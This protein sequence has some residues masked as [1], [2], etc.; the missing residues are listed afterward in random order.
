MRV[1]ERYVDACEGL[2]S[3]QP[4]PK[5][6]AGRLAR[7]CRPAFR[8]AVPQAARSFGSRR[9]TQ[10]SWTNLVKVVPSPM[11]A[12]MQPRNRGLLS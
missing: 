5:I 10:P 4:R 7:D 11:L 8:P 3:T 9:L 1:V 2:V 12:S 6:L